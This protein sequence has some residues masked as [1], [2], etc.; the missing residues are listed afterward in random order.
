[1]TPAH[2]DSS[3]KCREYRGS[4]AIGAVVY[5]IKHAPSAI[6]D[7]S[8]P[9]T[10]AASAI[11]ASSSSSSSSSSS[12]TEP[13]AQVDRQCIKHDGRRVL[14]VAAAVVA[15]R[16]LQSREDSA[17]TRSAA[18]PGKR[19]AFALL[20]FLHALAFHPTFPSHSAAA[21]AAAASYKPQPGEHMRR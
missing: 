19:K 7:T 12:A 16:W 11:L 14:A 21:V 20:L 2:L 1:M 6:D 3:V 15:V 5:T 18:Q 4:R 10:A 17:P 9:T 8:T 13:E